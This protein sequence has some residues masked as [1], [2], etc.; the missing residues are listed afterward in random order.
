[1]ALGPQLSETLRHYVRERGALPA[2]EEPL[3][4]AADGLPLDVQALNGLVRTVARR[5]G[6]FER[7]SAHVLRASVLARQHADAKRKGAVRSQEG[8]R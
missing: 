5:A 3:L 4:L 8:D 6:L 1:V 2:P 7:L